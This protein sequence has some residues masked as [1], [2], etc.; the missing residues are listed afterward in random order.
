MTFEEHPQ[1]YWLNI[2]ICDIQDRWLCS[3]SCNEKLWRAFS[4]KGFCYMTLQSFNLFFY[5][6]LVFS[7]S[8]HGKMFNNLRKCPNQTFCFQ[9]PDGAGIMIWN[10]FILVLLTLQKHSRENADAAYLT[11]CHYLSDQNIIFH[12]CL[13]VLWWRKL[14]N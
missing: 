3:H 4:M 7:P 8:S 12:C 5:F 6:T 9:V 11:V 2:R 1:K 14:K 13:Q 10:S